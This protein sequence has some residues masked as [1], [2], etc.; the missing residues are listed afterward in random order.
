MLFT[1]LHALLRWRPV[2]PGCALSRCALS[3]LDQ[4]HAWEAPY[5]ALDGVGRRRRQCYKKRP[6][7]ESRP[8]RGCL[9]P[10][11]PP[12]RLTRFETE[13]ARAAPLIYTGGTS[14]NVC[15]QGGPLLALVSGR[16]CKNPVCLFLPFSASAFFC[17]SL[18]SES[19]QERVSETGSDQGANNSSTE[20]RT[21]GF[22]LRR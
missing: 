9:R 18:P 16:A 20:S 7:K 2:R 4:L 13:A 6:S 10:F 17:L 11:F 21:Q 8:P 5:Q 12:T 19:F 14:I 15:T 22:T 3:R 1:R